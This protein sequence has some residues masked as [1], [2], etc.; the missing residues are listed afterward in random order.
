MLRM[1]SEKSPCCEP[2][3]LCFCQSCA[4]QLEEEQAHL[5]SMKLTRLMD[6]VLSGS[7]S[8]WTLPR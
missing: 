6:F 7:A 5:R 1:L 4:W 3:K 8:C 2:K